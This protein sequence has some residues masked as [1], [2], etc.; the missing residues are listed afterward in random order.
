MGLKKNKRKSSKAKFDA[1]QYL[2]DNA[3]A[4]WEV[5][6]EKVE[7]GVS[8]IRLTSVKSKSLTG[9]TEFGI[10][11]DIE[12]GTVSYDQ[13]VLP[14][15]EIPVKDAIIEY[16]TAHPNSDKNSIIQAVKPLTSIGENRI[17]AVLEKIT[18]GL[19]ILKAQKGLNNEKLY[20]VNQ[21]K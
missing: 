20:S 16:L 15:D 19:H 18:G 9:F 12:K 10:F 14:E 13:N 7:N 11:V 8:E 17:R 6:P 3:D 1:L 4:V 5:K 2:L 21:D